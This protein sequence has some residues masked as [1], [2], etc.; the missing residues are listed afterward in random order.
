MMT[1]KRFGCSVLLCAWLAVSARGECPGDLNNDS[2]VTV[3]ELITCI[4]QL[5]CPTCM[6]GASGQCLPS[7]DRNADGLISIDELI[8]GVNNALAGCP[9]V[10]PP[11]GRCRSQSPDCN[12]S[13]QLCL[14]PG[15]FVGCGI[16]YS[17]TDLDQFT[18]CNTDAECKAVV[19]DWI[20]GELGPFFRDCSP[21]FGPVF[22]CGPGCSGDDG[23]NEGET[24]EEH[25]CVSRRCSID[26][27]CPATFLCASYE[28][29]GRCERRSCT[30]DL[31]CPEGFCVNAACYPELGRCMAIPP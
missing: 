14:A 29:I 2:R 19:E 27:D 9:P 8:R 21:C 1:M 6:P 5:L 7:Y 30:S 28:P 20:C 4:Q 24:C 3:D 23:C 17:D 18:R 26:A 22:V 12:A 10:T 16:C 13:F 11:E 25:R 15:G 31:N